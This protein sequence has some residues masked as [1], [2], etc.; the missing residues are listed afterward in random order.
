MNTLRGW[1]LL[2]G[3]RQGKTVGKIVTVC[4]EFGTK[5]G[6]SGFELLEATK[7]RYYAT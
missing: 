4:D 1:L 3:A 6:E 7:S 5:T 2:C